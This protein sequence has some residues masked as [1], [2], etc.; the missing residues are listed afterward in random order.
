MKECKCERM[1]LILPLCVFQR[2][3]TTQKP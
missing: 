3:F 1:R 2:F